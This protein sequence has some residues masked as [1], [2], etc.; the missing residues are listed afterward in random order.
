MRFTAKC[1]PF[2][3]LLSAAAQTPAPKLWN[4]L[5]EKRAKLPAFHQEFEATSLY[6]TST[7][8]Q[9]SMKGGIVLDAAGPRWRESS[10][11]TGAARISIFDGTDSITLDEL[12]GEFTRNR[13]KSKADTPLPRPYSAAEAD[14]SKAIEL[15]RSRCEIPGVDHTCVNIEVPLKKWTRATSPNTFTR[16]TD[17][18]ARLRMDTETGLILL[19][20]TVRNFDN[21][22]AAYQADITYALKGIGPGDP[23]A[24]FP[25]PPGLKEVKSFTEWDASRMRKV[26]AGKPAPALRVQTIDGKVLDLASL[27]G[28]TVLLDFWTTWCP[29]CREDAPSIEKLQKKYGEKDLTIIGLSV[30]EDRAVV[31]KFL[32]DHPHSYATVLTSENEMPAQYQVNVFPTYIVIGTDGTLTSAVQGTKGFSELRS[33]LKQSGLGVD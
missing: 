32:R 27:K 21:G 19:L 23:T 1:A 10:T 13:Q 25:I 22:R 4:E 16:M 20:R 31:E 7:G 33:L 17:G 30:N 29:P 2:F 6:K 14:W 28:R 15:G 3:F 8:T 18:M 9:P 5:A 12:A 26:L 24:T 11:G